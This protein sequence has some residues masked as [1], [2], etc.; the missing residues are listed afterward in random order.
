MFPISAGPSHS[1]CNPQRKTNRQ[2]FRR[3]LFESLEARHLMTGLLPLSPA[4]DPPVSLPVSPPVSFPPVVMPPV[5]MPPVITPP[6]ALP[7]RITPPL[8]DLGGIYGP[9]ELVWI[10]DFEPTI[11]GGVPG[12]IRIERTNSNPPLE[13]MWNILTTSTAQQKIDY[14]P[15]LPIVKFA[16]G[17]TYIDVFFPVIDDPIPES[18]E[19]IQIVLSDTS[20]LGTWVSSDIAPLQI[21]DNDTANL[22]TFVEWIEFVDGEEGSRNA[23]VR[24]RRTGPLDSELLISYEIQSPSTLS[25][26][27]DLRFQRG[28]IDLKNR[29]GVLRFNPGAALTSSPWTVIDDELVEA[30]EW[31]DLQLVD[32]TDGS[33]RLAGRRKQTL[34]L[35]DNDSEELG[36]EPGN[37]DGRKVA[38]PT[39]SKVVLRSDTGASQ[40]DRITFD[41]SLIVSYEGDWVGGTL[42]SEFDWTGDGVPDFST[43]HQQ[44]PGDLVLNPRDIHPELANQP[45]PRAVHYRTRLLSEQG[46]EIQ[47]GNW[48]TFAYF[49][50]E[51]PDAGPIRLSDLRL[52]V[53]TGR[54]GDHITSNPTVIVDVLGSI[55]PEDPEWDTTLIE[56]DH[57]GDGVPDAVVPLRDPDTGSSDDNST[58]D[59]CIEYDPRTIDEHYSDSSGRKVIRA[60]LI[61][62][63]TG[64]RLT[65]WIAYE[66]ILLD[67]PSSTWTVDSIELESSHD[68]FSR[69][70]SGTV[71]GRL[72]HPEWNQDNGALGSYSPDHL[73]VVVDWDGDMQFDAV[74]PIADDF[75]FEHGLEH[76][77]PGKYSF[78]YRA[79]EW[80][81]E[82]QV[83]RYGPWRDYA[84][85]WNP[86]SPFTIESISLRTELNHG[87]E[88]DLLS[89]KSTNDPAIFIDISESLS[90]GLQGY[91]DI[92]VSGDESRRDQAD[93]AGSSIH[94]VPISS[95]ERI[96]FINPTITPGLQRY[97]IRTRV[98]DATRG[99][100]SIGDWQ[101][102]EWRYDPLEAPGVSLRL[103][104]DDGVSDSDRIT[105][106]STIVGRVLGAVDSNTTL[107]VDFDDPAIGKTRIR[108]LADGS[109]VVRFPNAIPGEHT[110]WIRTDGVNPYLGVRMLG[111]WQAFDFQLTEPST[112]AANSIQIRLLNDSGIDPMD[113]VSSVA[114]IVGSIPEPRRNLPGIYPVSQDVLWVEIDRDA[115]GNPDL[116]VPIDENGEFTFSPL[117]L[118][119]GTHLMRFR[120]RSIHPEWNQF[121]VSSWNSFDFTF[122]PTT[123][124]PLRIES[125]RLIDDTGIPGDRRSEKGGITGEIVSLFDVSNA[126]VLIDTNRDGQADDTISIDQE[127]RFRY[128]PN[129]SAH[130][131][132]TYAF[133]PLRLEPLMSTHGMEPWV[134]FTFVFE[135]QENQPPKTTDLVFFPSSPTQPPSIFGSVSAYGDT[136]QLLV[137]LDA[138]L[139]G[140][141]DRSIRVDAFGSFT[142]SLDY[143]P[144]G[145]MTIHVRVRDRTA[146]ESSF[147]VGAWQEIAVVIPPVPTE[148]PAILGM[149]FAGDQGSSGAGQGPDGSDD[150]RKT[151]GDVRVVGQVDRTSP[152]VPLSIEFDCDSDGFVDGQST[153]SEDRSFTFTPVNIPTGPFTIRARTKEILPSGSVLRSDWTLLS[154]N[155]ES[156]ATDLVAIASIRLQNNRGP[157]SSDQRSADPVIEGELQGEFNQRTDWILEVESDSLEVQ[158]ETFE[159]RGSRFSIAPAWRNSG[160]IDLRLRV[161]SLDGFQQ[162]PWASFQFLFHPQPLS[163]EADAW[164]A[165]FQSLKSNIASAQSVHVQ[166]VDSLLARFV[167]QR[168]TLVSEREVRNEA[169]LTDR[170]E[171]LRET[172]NRTWVETID[173][174][175]TRESQELLV[176]ETL[177][178]SLSVSDSGATQES[179]N[180]LLQLLP[181]MS[182]DWPTESVPEL[183]N[184]DRI[185]EG[186]QSSLPLP[187]VKKPSSELESLGG[188]SIDWENH[189]PYQRQLQ[190][191]ESDFQAKSLEIRQDVADRKKVASTARDRDLEFAETEY[192]EHLERIAVQFTRETNA[193]LPSGFTIDTSDY[194][195]RRRDT[196]AVHQREIEQINKRFRTLS[197]SIEA[198]SAALKLAAQRVR[199]QIKQAAARDLQSVLGQAPPPSCSALEEA[200]NRYARKIY[201]AD[202]DYDKEIL[203]IDTLVAELSDPLH[204]EKANLLSQSK[205]TYLQTTATIDKERNLARIESNHENSMRRSAA[206]TD[207]QLAIAQAELTYRLEIDAANTKY[208]KAHAAIERDMRLS[209]SQANGIR[210]IRT[211]Q[212][213]LTAAE[214]LHGM[215]ESPW[216]AYESELARQNLEQ[217]RALDLV[218]QEQMGE[219][220]ERWLRMSIQRMDALLL[221]AREDL[222]YGSQQRSERIE[223]IAK[224]R[225]DHAT[226]VKTFQVEQQELV[227]KSK[228]E[229]ELE[230][231]RNQL[232]SD[233]ISIDAMIRFDSIGRA[234]RQTRLS[235]QIYRGPDVNCGTMAIGWIGGDP[236]MWFH[237]SGAI[238]PMRAFEITRSFEE[239]SNQLNRE[240]QIKRVELEEAALNRRDEIIEEY[241]IAIN[242]LRIG[243]EVEEQDLLEVYHRSAAFIDRDHALNSADSLADYTNQ[244]AYLQSQ[245]SIDA[246]QQTERDERQRRDIQTEFAR[247]EREAR[248]DRLTQEWRLYLQEVERWRNLE[249][250]AW[251]DYILGQSRVEERVITVDIEQY[252]LEENRRAEIEMTKE[253]S[254]SESLSRQGVLQAQKNLDLQ[255]R[256]SQI[257]RQLTA[258]RLDATYRFSS[259]TAGV[260]SVIASTF[261]V[262][263]Q[264][265][266]TSG[267]RH[268]WKGPTYS[269][270]DSTLPIKKRLVADT[271]AANREQAEADFERAEGISGAK[272]QN[273]IAIQ[274]ATD[275]LNAN[276]IEWDRYVQMV[277]FAND[278][279]S[280]A[281]GHIEE[282]YQAAKQELNEV[283]RE[284]RAESVY[285]LNR[286]LAMRELPTAEWSYAES[287]PNLVLFES[288]KRNLDEAIS[289]AQTQAVIATRV[290]HG[291]FQAQ[292]AQIESAVNAQTER[293]EVDYTIAF[294]RLS[295]DSELAD[296]TRNY[297]FA[298]EVS[299]LQAALN[300]QHSLEYVQSLGG[301]FELLDPNAKALMTAQANLQDRRNAELADSERDTAIENARLAWQQAISSYSITREYQEAT[302]SNAGDLRESIAALEI[303]HSEESLEAQFEWMA[304]DESLMSRW[305]M[306]WNDIEFVYHDASQLAI[307]RFNQ[308][309]HT[310]REQAAERIAEVWRDYY[311]EIHSADA[312]QAMHVRGW[313]DGWLGVKQQ[314][315]SS[316]SMAWV[317][318]P[319]YPSSRFG[320]FNL[321]AKQ[322]ESLRSKLD[323]I[324]RV[325]RSNQTEQHVQFVLDQ[326]KAK[327]EWLR[328]IEES[329]LSIAEERLHSQQRY[330]EQQHEIDVRLQEN[331]QQMTRQSEID[332]DEDQVAYEASL[333]VV[334]QAF[335]LQEKNAN[336]L[337]RQHQDE[338]WIDYEAGLA[339]VKA[340]YWRERFVAGVQVN[341][342]SEPVDQWNSQFKNHAIVQHTIAMAGWVDDIKDDY[343]AWATQMARIKA[344]AGKHDQVASSDLASKQNQARLEHQHRTSA[345]QSSAIQQKQQVEHEYQVEKL[346]A[347]TQGKLARQQLDFEWERAD[348]ALRVDF[349]IAYQRAE[350]LE[351]IMRLRGVGEAQRVREHSLLIAEAQR[352]REIAAAIAV[353]KWRRGVL[354]LDVT[355]SV[356]SSAKSGDLAERLRAIESEASLVMLQ[357]DEDLADRLADAVTEHQRA[358]D[359]QRFER[360][361]SEQRAK[362][363]WALSAAIAGA[364]ATERLVGNFNGNWSEF[365][366]AQAREEVEAT[367][368]AQGI[369]YQTVERQIAIDQDYLERITNAQRLESEGLRQSE[370]RWGADQIRF[371]DG[372]ETARQKAIEEFVEEL[373]EPLRRTID[374][375]LDTELEYEK[376]LAEIK[377]EFAQSRDEESY[378]RSLEELS[379]Q[380]NQDELAAHRAWGSSRVFAIAQRREQEADF[381]EQL[382][383]WQLER[384][385]AI[386]R[387]ERDGSFITTQEEA[388]AYGDAVWGWADSEVDYA[389]EFAEMRIES[390]ERIDAAMRSEN[391]H[392]NAWSKF[393]RDNVYSQA[394]YEVRIANS[395]AEKRREDARNQVEHEQQQGATTKLWDAGEWVASAAAKDT[396]I[397]LDR[398]A[399]STVVGALRTYASS[400]WYSE[401]PVLLAAPSSNTEFVPQ[402]EK[403][404]YI[405]AAGYNA[406]FGDDRRY[407]A[408][409]FVDRAIREDLLIGK[410]APWEVLEVDVM[411]WRDTGFLEWVRSPSEQWGSG[412]W[413]T[414][415]R[416]NRELIDRQGEWSQADG[417]VARMDNPSAI[418]TSD[419]A[420]SIVPSAYKTPQIQVLPDSVEELQQ[421][422]EDL[423]GTGEH[424]DIFRWM[425]NHVRLLDA[426]QR[427]DYG[428]LII[429]RSTDWELLKS[430]REEVQPKPVSLD[431]FF[432]SDANQWSE[433]LGSLSIHYRSL[434]SMSS[435]PLEMEVGNK[436]RN[437]IDTKNWDSEVVLG[438]KKLLGQSKRDEVVRRGSDVYWRSLVPGGAV[439]KSGKVK[440]IETKIGRI[441]PHGWVY[442]ETG[443]RVLYSAIETWAGELQVGGPSEVSRLLDGL[444]SPY[445]FAPQSEQYGIFIA[446]TGMHFHGIGNVEKLYNVYEGSK[447]YYGGIGNPI[448]YPTASRVWADQAIGIGWA[449]IIERIE[450]DFLTFYKP[451]QKIHVF[452]WSRGA[453]MAHE[454]SKMLSVYNIEVDFLGLL[455][456]VYSYVYPGHS[457][458]L[459]EWSE[460]GRDGNFVKAVQS[461]NTKAMSIIYAANEDRSFFPATRFF[462]DDDLKLR[463]MKSPGGHGEIGGHFSSNLIVQRLNMRAMMELAELDGDAKFRFRGI[464]EDI[465][466]IYSSPIT[467]KVAIGTK[468]MEESGVFS[469]MKYDVAIEFENWV[470]LSQ[471]EYIFQLATANAISWA[472]SAFGSQQGNTLGFFT[473]TL[474]TVFSTINSLTVERR[475]PFLSHVKR[476]LDWCPMNLWDLPFVLD[477][478]GKSQIPEDRLKILRH[479]YS[480]R[481]DPEKGD[482]YANRWSE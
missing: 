100:D 161:R 10:S 358:T 411:R 399:E 285:D 145:E 98:R 289:Q 96:T 460:T 271:A 424:Q 52:R 3:V 130:G 282:E 482:W 166:G 73:S 121:D 397:T 67:I 175:D 349:Q 1:Q 245:E 6:S 149:D 264:A 33:Y 227:N 325:Q 173:A 380:R 359:E 129:L 219:A 277:Q 180:V 459:V 231:Q 279:Y 454:F 203:R 407:E 204:A 296:T 136:S 322:N 205:I 330:I 11:E 295:L 324:Q 326:G 386:A 187:N 390:A 464:D 138:N 125:I 220:S 151:V 450:A 233:L 470:P 417:K 156:I 259:E 58:S 94:S 396:L 356:E 79:Q 148:A 237:G 39:I 16:P 309:L 111:A 451:W 223:S 194:A 316:S 155:R 332:R 124:E 207:R 378:R 56:W 18:T 189:E 107:E 415:T 2:Q 335:D 108:P 88:F 308:R 393:N 426:N 242:S 478:N 372:I 197:Q 221:K 455:D 140:I 132:V 122:A 141:I 286:L 258:E 444:I 403:S 471:D 423:I 174:D 274:L 76:L 425:E 53:D 249:P 319:M 288:A 427:P 230:K 342:A 446:G 381:T 344:E 163:P 123:S 48:K 87:S 323:E 480:L 212:A 150:G 266:P 263:G 314:L 246:T 350:A 315:E 185:L 416:W 127:G 348:L 466:R 70:N 190:R 297:N 29:K 244:M 293:I 69:T 353:E 362:D 318:Q 418:I 25:L 225:A 329:R 400:G 7:P 195:R 412:H 211:A 327:T 20:R 382:L 419:M 468:I 8:N 265:W 238:S 243:K 394:E 430:P 336:Q 110:L 36:S 24:A 311:L 143:L 287:I 251:T 440:Y 93:Q 171:N 270:G 89:S 462:Q 42:I 116:Q 255:L 139:D 59:R 448:E 236:F 310:E 81:S 433:L 142:E 387:T 170:L 248:I 313:L 168:S 46:K 376:S 452:G 253:R 201:N 422:W 63:R 260:S 191:I 364:E 97:W 172:L 374:V 192:R 217:V 66:F 47:S 312:I 461:R 153:V 80:D 183:P 254:L 208:E 354:D 226:L 257:L 44:L 182:F 30:T 317:Q 224:Y 383:R 102:F 453:A 78:A 307:D 256:D 261:S 84:F 420:L 436:L 152:G 21:S 432:V 15:P 51:D 106:V 341:G 9:R 210:D 181:E 388:S 114:T 375:L 240:T 198:E 373:A 475:Q 28:E 206:D 479:M 113:R 169:S 193:L 333:V 328:A 35:L 291:E 445:V 408:T 31:C 458:M 202:L 273:C 147:A 165:A 409:V 176:T 252:R 72:S 27:Q 434:R 103:L 421:P 118:P 120:T 377:W 465:L 157:S 13:V 250:S 370:A 128:Y 85:E 389:E 119:F 160:V 391:R 232:D 339:G 247:Q 469:F 135:D 438:P 472:P 117:P 401:A 222:T 239:Q 112:P 109:F 40:A 164:V 442:L 209:I 334:K 137:E 443:K 283:L 22:G 392:G 126:V 268:P 90:H 14:Y 146:M 429:D 167:Y 303:Q 368:L 105:S 74:L 178:Q 300:K 216:S 366:V 199:D 294:N 447:F 19:L 343:V 99:W 402:V 395:N 367:R 37:S 476:Y 305:Q 86:I 60:R 23:V 214:Q 385:Q 115:D 177:R 218:N 71:R 234:N 77:A 463:L 337:S 154:G 439:D 302:E 262:G 95:Q 361:R 410:S 133:R 398:M 280:D 43:T 331:R 131:Q 34:R 431:R 299:L 82:S 267:N 41:E 54:V 62:D 162:S 481:I 196:E 45:G 363:T 365:L 435:T 320:D 413:E 235:A 91:L 134:D 351:Q 215:L 228:L 352:D 186:R 404:W 298:D 12:R 68:A 179:I 347:E 414:L 49:V 406:F 275:M 83:F 55:H 104:S 345:A 477:D 38:G 5:V 17:E 371:E 301:T 456:P 346:E 290:A 26:D 284:R 292:L 272:N 241:A 474:D 379:T 384:D 340:D 65:N 457:S 32:P 449:S 144:S 360:L 357:A 213:K 64:E 158:R 61:D 184:L 159:F 355:F 441:D 338:A 229:M 188:S 57:T 304:E 281:K 50:V 321:F 92:D 101:V 428:A 269:T 276:L 467:R 278:Q 405:N 306:E 473:T 437:H 75:T 369:Q 4:T 200:A